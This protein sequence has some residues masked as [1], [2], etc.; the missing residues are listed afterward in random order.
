MYLTFKREYE[1]FTIIKINLNIVKN[2]N[3]EYSYNEDNPY[4]EFNN[5]EYNNII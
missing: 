2:N 1:E 5:V 4:L 3:E